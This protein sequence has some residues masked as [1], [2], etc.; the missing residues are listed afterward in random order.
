MIPGIP[1]DILCYVAGAS[2]MRFVPFMAFST[3]G[4]LPGIIGSAVIGATA[5]TRG[6]LPAAIL[7]AVAALLLVVGVNRQSQLERVLSRWIT[8]RRNGS[9]DSDGSDS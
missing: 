2:G 4:R 7:M 5:A 9:T 3:V 8:R 1:K 6:V